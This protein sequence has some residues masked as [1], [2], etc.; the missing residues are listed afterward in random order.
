MSGACWEP[1]FGRVVQNGD[2]DV[3]SSDGVR[4]Q[5]QMRTVWELSWRLFVY[6]V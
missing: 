4:F 6:A 3:E 1:L 2:G 5:V